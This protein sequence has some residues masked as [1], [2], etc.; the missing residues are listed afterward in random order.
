MVDWTPDRNKMAVAVIVADPED[1]QSFIDILDTTCP[2]KTFDFAWPVK[3]GDMDP[4][5]TYKIDKYLSCQSLDQFRTACRQ[6]AELRSAIPFN[7]P[8]SAFKGVI[9]LSASAISST[10]AGS[11]ALSLVN[12]KG[13]EPIVVDEKGDLLSTPKND[14]I[15]FEDGD[16]FMIRD[17]LSFVMPT[18]IF[19]G[20]RH[21]KFGLYIP[22]TKTSNIAKVR[23]KFKPKIQVRFD[24]VPLDPK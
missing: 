17:N 14:V 15:T 9:C 16:S 4:T 13:E 2:I 11:S 7:A 20:N 3:T 5:K 6:D 22:T 18:D 23:L 21:S 24:H 10:P 1:K 19:S 12:S 8:A